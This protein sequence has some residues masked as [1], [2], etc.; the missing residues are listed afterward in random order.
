MNNKEIKQIT[1]N[2][3]PKLLYHRNNKN[4]RNNILLNLNLIKKFILRKSI[5]LK[6]IKVDNYL[7]Q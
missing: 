4:S 2:K 6:K 3:L 1:L 7:M 5:N